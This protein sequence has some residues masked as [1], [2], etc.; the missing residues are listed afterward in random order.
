MIVAVVVGVAGQA[1]IED[2]DRAVGLGLDHVPDVAALQ[3][4]VEAPGPSRPV[5]PSTLPRAGAGGAEVAAKA[6]SCS[7]VTSVSAGPYS[8]TAIRCGCR[9]VS[10]PLRTGVPISLVMRAGLQTVWS[11]LTAGRAERVPEGLQAALEQGARLRVVRQRARR[12]TNAPPLPD[13]LRYSG[14]GQPSSSER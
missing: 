14:A 8:A 4:L 6:R 12:Y 3:H 5:P 1:A 11:I 10:S 9:G 13:M 2:V 7:R